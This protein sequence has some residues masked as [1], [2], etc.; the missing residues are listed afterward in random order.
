[1]LDVDRS[2]NEDADEMS[3]LADNRSG[4]R[5]KGRVQSTSSSS[6]I[7]SPASDLDEHAPLSA[8]AGGSHT[9]RTPR[10]AARAAPVPAAAPAAGA[11]EGASEDDE[12]K[13][14]LSLS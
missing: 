3:G 6:S 1:M 12:Q 4:S 9:T 11:A 7:S 14:V 13:S 2:K 8:A 5:R 10:D